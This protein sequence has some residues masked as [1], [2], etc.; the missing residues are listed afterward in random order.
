MTNE[1]PNKDRTFEILSKLI[2]DVFS[3]HYNK[4]KKMQVESTDTPLQ[5]QKE[6]PPMGQDPRGNYKYENIPDYVQQTGKRFRMTKDQ[7][8]RGLTRYEAFNETFGGNN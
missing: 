5:E 4:E 1:T 2:D 8:Q 3:T 6:N 7:K